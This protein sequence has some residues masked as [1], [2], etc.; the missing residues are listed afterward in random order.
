MEREEKPKH[1]PVPM[2]P[3]TQTS[4]EIMIKIMVSPIIHLQDVYNY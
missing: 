2:E 3:S 1:L 4:A